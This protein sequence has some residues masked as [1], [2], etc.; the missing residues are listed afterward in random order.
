MTHLD[1]LVVESRPGAARH[2]KAALE[3]AGHTVHTCHEP[4]APGFP[5]RALDDAAVCPLDGGID[6][7]VVVRRGVQP[8]PTAF[9][10]GVSCIVKAGVPLLE[11]GS[12][13]LDPFAPYIEG[14]ITGDTVEAVEETAAGV[15]QALTD[16][17]RDRSAGLLEG[18]GVDPSAIAT[19]VEH[20]GPN[21]RITVSG[22]D[23]QPSMQHSICVRMLDVVRGTR[24]V[25]GQVDVRYRVVED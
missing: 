19:L 15:Q 6:V 20:V 14:Y 8:R 3:A 2:E 1:V 25:S 4:H 10:S 9:E 18:T 7:A 24:A 21:T 13:V 23:L 16:A 12:T 17:L 22:P 11:A 5:C